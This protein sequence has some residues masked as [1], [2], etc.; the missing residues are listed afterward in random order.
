MSTPALEP[1]EPNRRAWERAN[2]YFNSLKG[3]IDADSLRSHA[4]P[5]QVTDLFRVRE[6]TSVL[7][8]LCNDGRESAVWALDRGA[9]VHGVD[10][11]EAAISFAID[12]HRSLGLEASRFECADYL[13]HLRNTTLRYD[14]I[15]LTLGSLRWI[16]DLPE[17]FA[18]ARGALTEDG[19]VAVW[20]FHPHTLVHDNHGEITTAYPDGSSTRVR[21]HGVVDYAGDPSSYYLINRRTEVPSPISYEPQLET[22]IFADHS[23]AAI[24][25]AAAAAGLVLERVEEFDFVWEER[26]YPDLVVQ[27]GATFVRPDRANA[28]PLTLGC[29]WRAD[30]ARSRQE[31]S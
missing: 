2:L 1:T 21:Q 27:S 8:L 15:V 26:L 30:T 16:P 14:S 17:F 29:R 11:S 13:H 22:T 24:L 5:D 6:D 10:I 28:Y 4:F 18:A 23:V 20:D 9:V 25:N 7:H 3:T 31:P 12:L 19:V